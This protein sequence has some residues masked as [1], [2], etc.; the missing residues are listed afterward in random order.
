[1]VAHRIQRK[2]AVVSVRNLCAGHRLA[3]DDN[4]HAR[5]PFDSLQLSAS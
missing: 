2:S 3:P 5:R 1:M 4:G